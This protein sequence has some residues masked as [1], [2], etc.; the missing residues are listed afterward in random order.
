MA[1]ID[2][3]KLRLVKE[4]MA[5]PRQHH[6]ILVVDDEV[7][8]LAV[9][10]GMLEERYE[11][12]VCES[13][14]A[15]LE[16]LQQEGQRPFA[17]IISDQRMPGMTGVEFLEQSLPICPEAVRLILTGYTD[18][19][20]LMNAINRARIFQFMVKPVDRNHML[21]MVERAIEAYEREKELRQ[22]A[23][24]DQLTGLPNRSL[25]QDRIEHT[26]AAARRAKSSFAVTMLDIRRFKDVNDTLGHSAG[27]RVLR[28]VGGRLKKI[29]R[30]SDTVSRLSGGQ[31]GL[32]MPTV[33]RRDVG[34]VAEKMMSAIMQPLE[35]DGI[36]VDISCSIGV[37]IYP[38]H[39]EE[40]A[41]L[42][43]H[44]EIALY[45][46]K[47]GPSSNNCSVYDSALNKHSVLKLSLM[48]EL[49]RAIDNDELTL[50]FQPK[51]DMKTGK[52]MHAEALVRWIHPT[53]GF[54]GPDQFIPLAEQT[55]N[56]VH[57]TAWVLKAAVMQLS[58]WHGSGIPMS[59]AVNVSA[60]D[61]NNRG[62]CQMVSAN[63][64]QY[65]VPPSSLVLEIT[66]GSLM[67]DPQH[68]VATLNELC[69]LGVGLSIDDFGT[70]YSSMVQ[71]KRMPVDELKI[72][73]SF[74][75]HLDSDAEDMVIVKATI[76]LGHNLGLKVVGE[77]VEN[78]SIY[79]LLRDLGC[80]MAQGYYM[81]RPLPASEFGK[82]MA[83]SP[84]G[85]AKDAEG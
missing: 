46:A 79:N 12:V 61:L 45:A 3:S 43:Q 5:A 69:E 38:E 81:G 7:S 22:R 59:L 14:E 40:T 17:L 4:Q 76:D 1:L 85:G 35:I 80:D 51:I 33:T 36:P 52:A 57:L 8:N 50:Y 60:V 29:L 77:G 18:S 19:A 70:G 67:K 83:E 55:G 74:V 73:R 65:Q 53:H 63:L 72:D 34:V 49:R 64:A 84:Y 68:A 41:T 25:F 31:F 27:D 58:H 62:F 42:L 20:A 37:A 78:E 10:K 13:G 28:E 30:D 24:Y 6:R 11:V 71:L 54:I 16:V 47:G 23:L 15:A 56:I 2:K 21:L 44:A 32:L 9:M 66:E 39:G 82:W 26:I 75:A 48:S